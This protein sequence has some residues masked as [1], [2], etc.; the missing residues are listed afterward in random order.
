M[1]CYTI[2]R[3]YL[4]IHKPGDRKC[5]AKLFKD[6]VPITGIVWNPLRGRT[7]RLLP[8]PVGWRDLLRSA[9]RDKHHLRTQD[10]EEWL[11]SIASEKGDSG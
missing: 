8:L 5:H 6:H 3:T 7:L 11:C 4:G 10:L 9:W 1:C 2:L